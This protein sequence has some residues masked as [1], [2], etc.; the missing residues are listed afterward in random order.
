MIKDCYGSHTDYALYFDFII[1]FTDSELLKKLAEIKPEMHIFENV[2][3]LKA[4]D[5]KNLFQ[6]CK[7]I[8]LAVPQIEITEDNFESVF[9]GD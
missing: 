8:S 3:S 6:G 4:S 1:M 7:T 2:T 5:Y 9:G